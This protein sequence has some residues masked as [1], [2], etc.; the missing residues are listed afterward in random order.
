MLLLMTF[1]AASRCFLVVKLTIQVLQSF[2]IDELISEVL[3]TDLEIH[4]LTM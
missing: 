1:L 3:D 2:L 4:G